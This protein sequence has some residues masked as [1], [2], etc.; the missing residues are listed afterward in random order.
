MQ[1]LKN[2]VIYWQSK[3]KFVDAFQIWLQKL[4]NKCNKL[5][6]VF[7]IDRRDLYL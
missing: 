5:M 1:K 6:K 2:V 7:C 3:N 4:E